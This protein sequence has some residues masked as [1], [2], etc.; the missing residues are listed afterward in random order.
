M[1]QNVRHQVAPAQWTAAS[2]AL[3]PQGLQNQQGQGKQPSRQVIG[4]RTVQAPVGNMQQAPSF[5]FFKVPPLPTPQQQNL[6]M[7]APGASFPPLG[8]MPAEA[9]LAHCPSNASYCS[10]KQEEL[11]LHPSLANLKKNAPFEADAASILTGAMGGVMNTGVAEDWAQRTV[12]QQNPLQKTESQL[13][14]AQAQMLGLKEQRR[15]QDAA[16][17]AGTVAKPV[18]PIRA[19]LANRPYRQKI[20]LMRHGESEANISRRDVPDPNLTHLGHAQAKSWQESIGDFQAD[21]VLVSP[22]RRAVMTACHAFSY[23]EVPMVFCRFAREIGWSCNENTIHSTPASMEKLLDSLT[24]GDE[25]V[26]VKEALIAGPDDP[27][28]EMASLQRLK[29]AI[30]SRTEHNIVVVCHFGVIAA[31]TGCRAKNGDI[32][33]C[34]WGYNDELNTIQRHKTPISDQQCICG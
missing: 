18:S 23:E 13:V 33:E 24:R 5:S 28:D 2:F 3:P 9:P 17:A 27:A 30:A 12:R 1:A 19:I 11:N 10:D 32:Y 31:L 22:L 26:G 8:M 4:A 14:M 15:R 29:I 21:I 25:I 16:A 7:N 20:Y 6:F 34:E